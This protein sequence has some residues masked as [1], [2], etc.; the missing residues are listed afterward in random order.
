M[1]VHFLPALPVGKTYQLW[2]ITGQQALSAKV[3]QV[4]TLGH[5]SLMVPV[6][7]A[8]PDRFEITVEPAGGVTV[9][10]GPVL[11]YGRP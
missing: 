1:V 8:H 9:P 11:L 7:V 10:S 4:D 3:F 2:A 6:A 5:T